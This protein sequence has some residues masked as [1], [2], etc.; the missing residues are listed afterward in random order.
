TY[1]RKRD[2]AK[3]CE[4]A[5]N[6]YDIKILKCIEERLSVI[7]RFLVRYEKTDPK[8]EYD[9]LK[10]YRRD[11]I[12]DM[13]VSDV[14]Y[15]RRWQEAEY[16]SKE[17]AEGAPEIFTEKGERVRS[18]SEKIIADKLY[19]LGI[20][21]RYEYPITIG[22]TVLYPDFMILKMPEREEIYLEHLGMLDNEGY[23]ENVLFK[24]DTYERNGYFLGEK[25]FFTHETGK[26]PLNTKVLDNMLRRIL[27]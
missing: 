12:N 13:L 17:F 26:N 19:A 18:K 20:P 6:A 16:E 22:G 1:I 4:L 15:I 10:S 21:Y 7:K 9:K 14:A 25:L 2:K 11:I 8:K 5:Q 23:A 24:L 3:A 27:L